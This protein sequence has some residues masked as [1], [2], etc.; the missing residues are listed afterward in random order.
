MDSK[1]KLLIEYV[2]LEV[3]EEQETPEVQESV[4]KQLLNSVVILIPW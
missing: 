4:Y 3:R 1:D 2:T